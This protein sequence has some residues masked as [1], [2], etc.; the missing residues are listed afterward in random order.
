MHC[1]TRSV[2]NLEVAANIVNQIPYTP[3]GD[4]CEMSPKMCPEIFPKPHLYVV[5][6]TADHDKNNAEE[7]RFT[8]RLRTGIIV[9][10]IG[11]VAFIKSSENFE[12]A[13]LCMILGFTK[14]SAQVHFVYGK[15]SVSFQE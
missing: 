2:C 9:P 5:L 14:T 15:I 13:C 8:S 7:R 4:C 11:D 6:R 1:G 12:R 10:K 3:K